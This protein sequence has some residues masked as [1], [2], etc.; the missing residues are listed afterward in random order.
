MSNQFYGFNDFSERLICLK[1][2]S[3]KM[4]T[5]VVVGTYLEHIV[6]KYCLSKY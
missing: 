6:P 5:S 1:N 3:I 2:I 4:S